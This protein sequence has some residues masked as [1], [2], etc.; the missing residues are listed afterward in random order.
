MSIYDQ[1][2]IPRLKSVLEETSARL[3]LPPTSIEKDWWVSI[4]LE[5]LYADDVMGKRLTFKGGTSLSK[6]F[7]RIHSWLDYETMKPGSFVFVP[8]E[9]RMEFWHRDYEVFRSEMIYGDTPA[10]TE[11]IEQITEIQIAANSVKI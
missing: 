2:K 10:F 9:N 4:V 6:A 3:N 5:A 8:Q 11:I 1:L 7:N